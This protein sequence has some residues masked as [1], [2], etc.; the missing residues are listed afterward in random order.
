MVKKKPVLLIVEDD[1]VLL[2]ALYLFFQKEGKYTIASA[3]DGETGLKMA[4]R[5]N[6]DIIL[7]DIL[8]PKMNGFEV[9]KN[10]KSIAE[11]KNIPVIIL[12][13]LGDRSDI[14][15]AKELGSTDYFVKAETNL[16][17]LLG[18]IKSILK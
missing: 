14:E 6:P 11:L 16:S 8:M 15:K 9:L 12:S 10:L 18:K 2:R 1:E 7:L 5:L 3:T 17:V 4:G 13:N